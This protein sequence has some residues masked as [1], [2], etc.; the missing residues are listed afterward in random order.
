MRSRCYCPLY[1]WNG[2]RTQQWSTL[3]ASLKSLAVIY[4]LVFAAAGLSVVVLHTLIDNK[5][6]HWSAWIVVA[7]AIA[8]GTLA[9]IDNVR[10]IVYNRQ[11]YEREKA[12]SEMHQPLIGAL[13]SILEARKV[14]L[15]P[16][17]IS[18]FV[19]RRTWGLNW[20]VVPWRGKQL[21]QIFR[22]RL[23]NYPPE[24]AVR[25]TRGKGAI[26]ACWENSIPVLQNRRE[27]AAR[28]GEKG[29]PPTK[30]NYNELPEEDRSGFTRLEF[31]QTI[32]NW[33][34]ILAVP[35]WAENAARLIGVLSIDCLMSYYTTP[36]MKVLDY[37]E[38]RVFARG[39]AFAVQE[40]ASKF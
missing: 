4:R 7:V 38:V 2:H 13:N 37:D 16:L 34:E 32:D 20:W 25:W 15:D 8:V 36:D 3:G 18:V 5:L 29:Q 30:E 9:F 40:D 12:R 23:S 6:V 19:I 27:V 33:G 24:A 10:V 17:G 31:I 35:I 39:A 1:R 26:G 28:Y 22:F 11:A 21:K 14:P